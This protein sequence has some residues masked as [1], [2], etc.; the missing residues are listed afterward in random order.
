M[1]EQELLAVFDELMEAFRLKGRRSGYTTVKTGNINDTY[2]L[3]TLLPDGTIRRYTVQRINHYVF[4]EPEQVAGNAYAVTEHIAQKMREAGET[5]VRRGVVHYYRL[6]DG[7]FFYQRPDGN[8]WRVFSYIY[9][10]LN[11]SEADDRILYGTGVAFGR[12]QRYLADFPVDDLYV[13]IPDFHNTPKRFRDLEVSAD[14]DICGRKAEAEEALNWLL[15]MKQEVLLLER[16]HREGKLPLRVVHNDTKCNNVMFD[17]ETLRP[18]AV[19]DLDT[20]MPGFVAHDFGD[21]VRFACNTAAEDAGELSSVSLSLK[22]F[23]QFSSGFVGELQGILTDT[24]YE[25]LPEGV[26]IITLELAARFL[27]DYLDGDV[28]FKCHFDRHNLLRANCQIALAKDVALKLP[29]MHRLLQEL[30]VHK[31]EKIW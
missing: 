13:T 5:D 6:R 14:A 10:S 2:I 18:L 12:F 1:T 31:A 11:T 22:A 23:R 7:R 16:L 21:A 28:Y 24:E 17:R 25:T 20:V 26:L 19:I 27:K 3:E 29:E 4:R 15:S 8:Y 30:P 9:D